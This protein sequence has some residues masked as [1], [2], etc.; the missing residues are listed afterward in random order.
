MVLTVGGAPV[1]SP[2]MSAA[3]PVSLFEDFCK[4]FT[5]DGKIATH[6]SGVTGDGHLGLQSL[7]DFMLC[8]DSEASI[9]EVMVSTCPELDRALKPLQAARVR[10]R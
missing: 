2:Q 10:P 4:Q 6:C 7:G 5:I 9:V 1:A 3:D 8:G